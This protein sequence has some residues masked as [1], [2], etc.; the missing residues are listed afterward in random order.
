MR[1]C[2]FCNQRVSSKEHAWPLWLLRVLRPLGIA[3]ATIHAERGGQS[4]KSWQV[5]DDGM[6][7]RCVCASCNN[8]WMSELEN[9]AKPVIERLLSDGRKT[10][11]ADDQQRLSTWAMKNAMVFEAVRSGQPK[12]Y[13]DHERQVLRGSGLPPRRTTVWIAKCVNQPHAY[14]SALDLSGA[15]D[16]TTQRVDAYVTTMAFGSLALQ[17]LSGR[18]PEGVPATTTV[19]AELRP[20]PW[21][22][23]VLRVWP[24]AANEIEWPHRMGLDGDIGIEAFSE[25]WSP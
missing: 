19:T 3:R 15:V 2:L 1:K 16:G 21:D 20:G 13:S 25:R 4:P 24:I 23:V 11:N 18:L 9:A 7:V 8:G 10:L 6:T 14:S 22:E 5:V 12:F 17:V